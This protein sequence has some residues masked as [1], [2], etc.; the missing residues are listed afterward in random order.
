MSNR[1]FSLSEIASKLREYAMV[2]SVGAFVDSPN[3]L[4][5]IATT[6]EKGGFNEQLRQTTLVKLRESIWRE[7]CDEPWKKP[8]LEQVDSILLKGSPNFTA[9][10]TLLETG[11][12]PVETCTQIMRLVAVQSSSLVR[13]HLYSY[14]Y[15]LLVE[16]AYDQVLRFLWAVYTK[17]PSSNADIKS[18]CDNLRRANM[19]SA[20]VEGWN[21]TVRNAIAHATYSLDA[22]RDMANFEDKIAHTSVQ[23]SFA[24]L[25]LLVH[26]VYHV[27][28]AV[29]TILIG[30]TMVFVAFDEARKTMQAS[31][32]T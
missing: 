31:K 2:L 16:G 10:L 8:L 25:S 28:I 29:S 30:R 12:E 9:A 15:L 18:I 20:L 17:S 21:P 14:I 27:G 24:D 1:L 7:F 3:I 13:M 23:L 4:R 22:N 19:G 32:K 11:R 26:K 5:S 6:L